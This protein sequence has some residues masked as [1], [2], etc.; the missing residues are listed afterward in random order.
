MEMK[1]K[2]ACVGLGFSLCFAFGKVKEALAKK[3]DNTHKVAVLRLTGMIADVGFPGGRFINVDSLSQE[4]GTIS[5]MKN[6]RAVCLQINSPGGSPVQSE[7]IYRR[8]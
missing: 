4:I 8:R 3:N 5:A 1:K 7:L 2:I 6:F